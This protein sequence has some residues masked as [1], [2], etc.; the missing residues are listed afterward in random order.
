MQKH[1][2]FV[3]LHQEV[4]KTAQRNL[5][6]H[7]SNYSASMP[8]WERRLKAYFQLWDTESDKSKT[9]KI[10]HFLTWLREHKFTPIGDKNRLQTE[11]FEYTSLMLVAADE[12]IEVA[13]HH[14]LKK[15]RLRFLTEFCYE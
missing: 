14:D 13:Y 2:C 10:D 7:I 12:F 1:I 3:A 4:G 6:L 5:F 8:S 11:N 9:I 15:P